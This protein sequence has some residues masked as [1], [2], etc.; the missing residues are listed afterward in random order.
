MSLLGGDEG[1]E[2]P[3][4]PA[5]ARTVGWWWKVGIAAAV[6][7]LASFFVLSVFVLMVGGFDPGNTFGVSDAFLNG[8]LVVG[9]GLLGG[10]VVGLVGTFNSP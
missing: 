8:V 3:D 6:A 9:A 2:S 10:V 4:G 5:N 1:T 7:P